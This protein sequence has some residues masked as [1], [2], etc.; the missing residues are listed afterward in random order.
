M[1][2]NKLLPPEVPVARFYS[3]P[4][5]FWNAHFLENNHSTINRFCNLR[6]ARC[7]T[8]DGF[9]MSCF[10]AGEFGFFTFSQCGISRGRDPVLARQ[11]TVA[12]S[13]SGHPA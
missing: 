10:I 2:T 7:I 12:F 5:F 4:Q 11:C 9:S 1:S 3:G 6:S 13:C 8:G